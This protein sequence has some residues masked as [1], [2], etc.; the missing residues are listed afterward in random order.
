M[1]D[2]CDQSAAAGDML[3]KA[4]LSNAR[5]KPESHIEIIYCQGCGE[6]IPKNRRKAIPG[7]R[8][9]VECQS[10]EEKNGR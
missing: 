4:A 5:C 7:C 8:L 9:C 3:F 1:S 2:Y 6:E 10:M